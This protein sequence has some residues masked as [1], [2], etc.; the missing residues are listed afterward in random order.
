LK[1]NSSQKFK[2]LTAVDEDFF[3]KK[4]FD[5]TKIKFLII[6]SICFLSQVFAQDAP[7]NFQYNQSRFQAF[8]LFLEGDIDGSSLK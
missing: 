7:D 3:A 4:E 6:Y 5:M 1:N 8:Y 2:F